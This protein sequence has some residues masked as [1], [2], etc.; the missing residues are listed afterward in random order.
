MNHRLILHIGTQK[1]GTTTIQSFL[2]DNS[3]YLE[4]KGY[5]YPD[6]SFVTSQIYF[7]HNRN[8]FQLFR[9]S[10]NKEDWKKSIEYISEL[11]VDYDVILSEETIFLTKDKL[12]WE[13]LSELNERFNVQVICYLRRQDRFIEANWQTRVRNGT[14]GI[15]SVNRD[16][17]SGCYYT[18]L[19]KFAKLFG[20]E[21]IIVRPFEKMQLV[22]G[23]VLS[24]FC[25][26]IGLEIPTGYI[27]IRENERMDSDYLRLKA[28]INQIM[29]EDE[30]E[31][32]LFNVKN[33]ALFEENRDYVTPNRNKNYM[34]IENRLDLMKTYADQNEK[35]ARLYL[36]RTDGILFYE[37]VEDENLEVSDYSFMSEKVFD[38]L[39]RLY[40]KQQ[41]E[42]RAL[43]R[44][45]CIDQKRML[46]FF[47]GG[48]N[49]VFFLNKGAKPDY[50]IDNDSNKNGKTLEGVPII[51]PSDISDW[52]KYYILITPKNKT[53][54]KAQLESYGLV[55]GIDFE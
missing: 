37:N 15:F 29:L 8:L 32:I 21:S 52:K 4:Q 10:Y 7:Q 26:L 49:A 39:F 46:A 18:Q 6:F 1:T 45:L 38:I 41:Q 53:A 5:I 47:G 35:V 42:I 55:E 54:I 36:K 48:R 20:R 16:Y 31:R 43:K 13:L 11:L 12:F 33:Q 3:S 28:I 27:S 24:D 51:H 22:D 30:Y 19:E 2:V 44:Q 25:K 40:L 23:D 14:D 9:S 50:I 17:E 34:S